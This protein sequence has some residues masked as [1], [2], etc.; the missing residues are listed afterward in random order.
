M[1]LR[2]FFS[3]RPEASR[4]TLGEVENL[5]AFVDQLWRDTSYGNI[6]IDYQVSGLFQLPDD[7]SDYIDDLSNGDLSQGGKFTKVLLDAIANSSPDEGLDWSDLDAVMVVMAETGSEFHRGQGSPSCNVPQGPGGAVEN[8]GCAIFSENPTTNEN[9]VWGRWAHEVGHVLQQGG[10]AHPSNYNSEFELMDSNYPGQTGV[11]EK[12]EGIAFPGWLPPSKYLLFD[13]ASGGGTAN[14]WAEEHDPTGIPNVQAV[15][16]EI[17]GGLYY[18]ISVRRRVLGDDLN[19]DFS[20]FGIPDEGVLIERVSEGADPWVMVQG[21][22]GDRNV[23]WKEGET[24]TN[25]SDGIMISVAQKIDEDNY[26]V[27]V[28]FDD[29]AFIQPDVAMEPW[30]SPPGNT[31]ETTD[32][33]VDGPV[34]GY[35]KYRYGFWNDLKGN[36]VPRLNGD[37]P[38]IGLVNRL[39]ARIRNIGMNTASAVRVTWEITDPPGV[40]IAA[41]EGWVTIGSVDQSAFPSLAN[42]LAGDFVDVYVPWTPDFSIPEKDLEDG[43]F[44]LHTCLRVTIDPVAGET[45]FGNQDGDEEQENISTF[46]VSEEDAGVPVTTVLRLYNDSLVAPKF[47]HIS[48]ED[49]LPDSWLLDVNGGELDMELGPGEVRNVAVSITPVGPAALGSLFRV[50]LKASFQRDLVSDLDPTDVHH[51]FKVLGG[52]SV[53]ARVMRRPQ[54]ECEVEETSDGLLVG[55]SLAVADFSSFYDEQNPLQVL[56]ACVD[57]GRKFAE[58]TDLAVVDGEGTF[59]GLLHAAGATDCPEIACLFAGTDMLTTAAS[60]YVGVGAISSEIFSDGF[61]AGNTSAWSQT[62]P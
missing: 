60:G 46:E 37:F 16:A 8:T 35:D 40:G 7:R 51:E 22:N 30:R 11:F 19:G 41:A 31:W 6:S 3:D 48:Y 24:Y 9:Q 55:G 44:A 29:Q 56:I 13:I 33:W 21:P 4:F 54:L 42:I 23:L 45:V 25:T 15:R 28:G 43:H 39:Y 58:R 59:G 36:P 52:A 62:V 26:Q 2:V 49:D 32:I 5:F 20:P 10:P 50:D 17:T 27:R 53:Q 12:Q 1:V 38:A 14:L 61:E 57:E 34:N 47:F 18:L